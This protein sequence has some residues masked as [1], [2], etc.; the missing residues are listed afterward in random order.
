MFLKV[1]PVH[2]SICPVVPGEPTFPEPMCHV[3]PLHAG[4]GSIALSASTHTNLLWTLLPG[5]SVPASPHGILISGCII[6]RNHWNHIMV[7]LK[8][9]PHLLFHVYPPLRKPFIPLA[10]SI[11]MTEVRMGFPGGACGK[12]FAGQCRRRKR[13]GFNPWIGRIS[14]RRV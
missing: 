12:E 10:F 7:L 3:A 8:S 2:P 6:L 11:C 1:S 4:R 5:P 14:W 13:R 9:Y